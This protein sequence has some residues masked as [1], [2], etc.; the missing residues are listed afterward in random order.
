MITRTRH[1]GKREFCIALYNKWLLENGADPSDYTVDYRH[2]WF[3]VGRKGKPEIREHRADLTAE[4]SRLKKAGTFRAVYSTQ[5]KSY[6]L[7]R[8]YSNTS[9]LE[10]E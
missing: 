4:A 1:Q 3:C 6:L 5:Y 10:E 2:G 8:N 7:R 9:Y